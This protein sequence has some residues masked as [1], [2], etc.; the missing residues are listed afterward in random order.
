MFSTGF[1]AIRRMN[2]GYQCV[3][4]RDQRARPV[5]LGCHP[6]QLGLDGSRTACAPRTPSCPPR[7]VSIWRIR[8]TSWVPSASRPTG[9]FLATIRSASRRYASSI[10]S[11]EPNTSSRGSRYAPL[12]SRIVGSSGISESTSPAVRFEVGLEADAGVRMPGPELAVQVERPVDVRG[13][14]HVEPQPV[15]VL[16][17]DARELL[18]V[19]ERH[20]WVL[21][22]PEVAGLDGELGLET[23]G[24][25]AVVGPSIALNDATGIRRLGHVLA[26]RREHRRE[27]RSLQ[28]LRGGDRVVERLPGMNRRTLRRTKRYLGKVLAG[29]SGCRPP[30]TRRRERVPWVQ[31]SERARRS[32]RLPSGERRPG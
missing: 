16:G 7:S 31:P 29:A 1:S 17:R 8:P 23:F 13:R 26:Q 3:P 2:H 5:A 14:F 9:P 21:V 15:V 19:G 32:G 25:H 28:A 12:T 20:G 6:Q 11:R 4:V 18:E 24:G 30:T 22:E 27:P 10:T